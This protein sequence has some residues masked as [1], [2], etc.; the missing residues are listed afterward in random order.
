MLSPSNLAAA[1]PSTFSVVVSQ[2]QSPTPSRAQVCACGTS[3]D[4]RHKRP[5]RVTGRPITRLGAFF[6]RGHTSCTKLKKVVRYKIRSAVQNPRSRSVAR[7]LRGTSNSRGEGKGGD[8][9]VGREFA[10]RG[11]TAGPAG[12]KE[13]EMRDTGTRP[14]DHLHP[15]YLSRPSSS[16]SP[17]VVALGTFACTAQN[18][19]GSRTVTE[20]RSTEMRSWVAASRARER[21]CGLCRLLRRRRRGRERRDLEPAAAPFA[22]TTLSWSARSFT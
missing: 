14:L 13:S 9:G 8:V 6:S 3:V 5:A 21:V 19:T 1:T 12:V 2:W 17:G 22:V 4:V 20:A 16:S 11:T 7:A 15:C 18:R 10:L